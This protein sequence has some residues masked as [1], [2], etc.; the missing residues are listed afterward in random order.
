MG[1][2]SWTN[3]VPRA[4]RVLLERANLSLSLSL[5]VMARARARSRRAQ[6]FLLAKNET[7]AM[8]GKD[9]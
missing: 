9:T 4:L 3:Y 2:K 1:L 5:L 8:S 6:H 7:S